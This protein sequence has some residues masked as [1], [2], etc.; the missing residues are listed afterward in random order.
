[1][2]YEQKSISEIHPGWKKSIVTKAFE[3]LERG[4]ARE[5][6]RLAGLPC[7]VLRYDYDVDYDGLTESVKIL[8]GFSNRVSAID[9][10]DQ[11]IQ[12]LFHESLAKSRW[13]PT[14]AKV[15]MARDQG[16]AVGTHPSADVQR[17]HR[18]TFELKCMENYDSMTIQVEVIEVS[19]VEAIGSPL[20]SY[21]DKEEEWVGFLMSKGGM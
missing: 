12:K 18:R 20:F 3:S 2:N 13:S 7:I 6:E 21:L 1:M 19:G 5:R 15:E 8:E 4:I 14:S 17:V 10:A 9:C 11:L 16:V